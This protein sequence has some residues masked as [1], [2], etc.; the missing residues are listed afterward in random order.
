MTRTTTPRRQPSGRLRVLALL[1]LL[2]CTLSSRAQDWKADLERATKV[3]H[4]E[5]LSLEMELH[6]YTPPTATVPAS[7]EK[8][9]M[10][11][12]GDRYRVKQFGMEMIHTP[13]YMVLIDQNNRVIS[14]AQ[15][16]PAQKKSELSPETKEL[17]EQAVKELVETL[18]IDTVF[19]TP[20]FTAENGGKRSGSQIYRFV[21]TQ[22]KYSESTVYL[23]E[24]T[25]L[26]EKVSCLLRDP[27]E[28]E[29]GI[30]SRVR[31]DFHF[32][33]QAGDKKPDNRLFSTDKI[34]TVNAQGEILLQDP[35]KDYR[36]I[37]N[38]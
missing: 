24:K 27:V 17:F 34:F 18:G 25:G 32:L 7:K 19:S 2:S 10:Y 3:Y 38:R 5:N 36:L 14:I 33:K 22:G 31:I 12:A 6:F 37:V 8:V 23:S 28:T 20:R 1:C 13:E 30:F 4:S 11:K 16:K 9:S 26:I 21:Y 35:Y 29:E 15:N